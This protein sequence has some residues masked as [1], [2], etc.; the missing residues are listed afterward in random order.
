M[1]NYGTTK[2]ESLPYPFVCYPGSGGTFIGFRQTRDGN[3]YFCSCFKKAILN[4][5]KLRIS[6]GRTYTT[7]STTNFILSDID[8]P[9]KLVKQLMKLRIK[10]A[11][12]IIKYLHFK[13]KLCHECNKV[14]PRYRDS[15]SRISW[16]VGGTSFN[17]HFGWYIN[18]QC[19][20]WGMDPNSGMIYLYDELPNKIKNVIETYSKLIEMQE[21]DRGAWKI[22]I[23][24]GHQIYNIIEN[25]VRM[26]WDMKKMGDKW[27]NET[28][29]YNMIKSLMPDD[30]IKRHY[31]PD[32]LDRLE[33][34]IYIPKLRV[35]IEYQGAQHFGPIACWGGSEGFKKIQK[36]DTKKKRLCKANGIKLIYFY[37]YENITESLIRKKV[38]L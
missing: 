4:Y 3:F 35:G 2:K 8:F 30:Q 32:V 15:D 12:S 24:R 20:E 29:L 13:D 19:Y 18:K 17:Q 36:R 21:S 25:E 11:P 16:S 34:D 38:G 6:Q 1:V 14:I 37:Y 22:S 33:L 27:L 28:M 9:F 10:E 26:K 31:K 23:E 7:W 5:I